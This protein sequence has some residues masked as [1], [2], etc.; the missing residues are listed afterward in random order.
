M[1]SAMN[2]AS[3]YRNP[4]CL[5]LGLKRLLRWPSRPEPG[6]RVL[7]RSD[8]AWLS[9]DCRRCSCSA[10]ILSWV[11]LTAR[12][13]LDYQTTIN[14]KKKTDFRLASGT[15][16]WVRA[17]CCD[18]YLV[19][20]YAAPSEGALHTWVDT[21]KRIKHYLQAKTMPPAPTFHPFQNICP[22][23]PPP[24]PHPASWYPL[25]TWH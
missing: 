15:D 21:A 12:I 20:R 8:S 6:E 1:Q 23:P 10:S 25:R 9:Q 14:G 7:R 11:Q 5:L 3:L 19:V 17:I 4:Q 18:V 16:T 24:P 22:P 13:K 2:P